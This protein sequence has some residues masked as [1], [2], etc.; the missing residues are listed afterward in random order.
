MEMTKNV[1]DKVRND[2]ENIVVTDSR[3]NS[4]AFLA[5][6][7]RV[8]MVAA[9]NIVGVKSSIIYDTKSDVTVEK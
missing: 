3:T 5:K 9:R 4:D 8:S 6:E 1:N 7:T 2:N